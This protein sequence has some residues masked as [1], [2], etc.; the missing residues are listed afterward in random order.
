MP[1]NDMTPEQ[2]KHELANAEQQKKALQHLLSRAT[3][4]IEGLI[5]S[6]CDPEVKEQAGEK[7]QRFRRAVDL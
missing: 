6:D 2:L 3:D 1:H 7:V 4:E 5:E